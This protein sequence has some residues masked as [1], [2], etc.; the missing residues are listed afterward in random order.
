MS[1]FVPAA[2]MRSPRTATAPFSITRLSASIVMT[3][4]ALQIQ[5][6]GSAHAVHAASASR[7]QK[8]RI[9]R[10]REKIAHPQH[11]GLA[12]RTRQDD[13]NIAAEFPEN[14]PARP[15]RGCEQVRVRRYGYP[16]ELARTLRNGFE[17]C[18]AL[19]A[20]R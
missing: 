17:H 5:S 9:E 2:R 14:L 12:A 6:T 20:H 10:S 4:R 1:R 18:H 16:P 7:L 8:R 15:A 13:L 11:I 3:K 19:G